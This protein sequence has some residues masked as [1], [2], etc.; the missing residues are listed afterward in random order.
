MD[1]QIWPAGTDEP[2]LAICSLEPERQ[3]ADPWT[4][5]RHLHHECIP[6]STQFAAHTQPTVPILVTWGTSSR[7][8]GCQWVC[9]RRRPPACTRVSAHHFGGGVRGRSVYA[10]PLRVAFEHRTSFWVPKSMVSG[11]SHPPIVTTCPQTLDLR[12]DSLRCQSL[13][14]RCNCQPIRFP[15]SK[16]G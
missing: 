10:P 7:V 15:A 9:I 2:N 11:Y 12:V 13:S 1:C 3:V 6:I 8:I 5:W 14:I 4:S 16:L